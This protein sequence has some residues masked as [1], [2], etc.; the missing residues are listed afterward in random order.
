[1]VKQVSVFTGATLL[2][3]AVNLDYDSRVIDALRSK[4]PESCCSGVCTAKSCSVLLLGLTGGPANP[5]G[6]G[7]PVSPLSPWKERGETIQQ[8]TLRGS[9]RLQCRQ[10]TKKK[11]LIWWMLSSY[12]TLILTND[13][14]T[15]IMLHSKIPAG[16]YA[17]LLL[18]SYF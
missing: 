3:P 15:S 6:P 9:F 17:F 13:S 18:Y 4:T 2:T 8:N 14:E 5:A 11:R 1:M 7:G 10:K 16:S 12:K